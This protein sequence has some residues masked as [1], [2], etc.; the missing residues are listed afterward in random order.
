MMIPLLQRHKLIIEY[1]INR[2]GWT[3][4]SEISKENNRFFI[5]GKEIYRRYLLCSVVMDG[6]FESLLDLYNYSPYL[7]EV[8]LIKIKN[9]LLKNI[10][11][12]DFVFSDLDLVSLIIHC[13]VSVQRMK[14]KIVIPICLKL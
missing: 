4:A 7:K 6:T 9:I 14:Q 3:K 2:N 10:E 12:S 8:D 11:D 5:E 13:A 1:L